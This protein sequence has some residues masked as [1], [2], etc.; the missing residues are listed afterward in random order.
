MSAPKIG[1][2]FPADTKFTYIPYQKEQADFK[3]CGV[4]IPYN[5]SQGKSI[6][7]H[8]PQSHNLP[9]SRRSPPVS[10]RSPSNPLR[11]PFNFRPL[12]PTFHACSSRPQANPSPEWQDKKVVL[13]ALPGAFTPTCS[14]THLPDY[15]AK[16]SDLRAKG[17]DVVAVLASNDPFVMSA[18][19]KANG[20]KDDSILFLS[21]IDA[22]FSEKYGWA[23]GGRTGRYALIIDHGKIKYAEIEKGK[24]EVTVS[25]VDAV[26]AH[27]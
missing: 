27:L 8:H 4:P 9:I 25:G 21:D 2:Q 23:Q 11:S 1:D 6:P 16:L 20:V 7:L 26:L 12:H 3:T 13:F 5:A 10:L 24:G 19:A 14:G 15:I 22:A 17:V 18:W